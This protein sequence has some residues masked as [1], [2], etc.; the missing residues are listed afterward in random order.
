V[1]IE[2]SLPGDHEAYVQV[3]RSTVNRFGLEAGHV[4][5]VR[6]ALGSVTMEAPALPVTP[7]LDDLEPVPVH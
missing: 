6:P 2:L 7:L 3:T 5:H 1:R 4:I